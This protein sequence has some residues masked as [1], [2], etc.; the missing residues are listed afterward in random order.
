M[1]LYHCPTALF[2]C[3]FIPI[4]LLI[5]LLLYVHLARKLNRP[6]SQGSNQTSDWTLEIAPLNSPASVHSYKKHHARIYPHKRSD[7][8][9]TFCCDTKIISIVPV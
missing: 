2:L 1:L 4:S 8:Y 7:E 9:L 3:M 5:G 6:I